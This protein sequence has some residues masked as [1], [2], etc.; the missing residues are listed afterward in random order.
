M[1][2]ITAFADRK[3]GEKY[4]L[5]KH[6]SGL[7]IYV[8]PKKMTL[9]TALLGV[10]FGSV[11]ETGA[12]ADGVRREYPSGIAHF[13]EHKLFSSADGVDA[14]EVL[15]SLGAD[16]NAY[17]SNNKTVYMFSCTE[18]FTAAL[19]ELVNF[20][21][22][23][24][25]TNENVESERGI[26]TQEIRMCNDS[27]YDA[28][29][30]NLLHALFGKGKLSDDV[31]GTER[32][33]DRIDAKTL[34]D[35]YDAFYRYSNM[36]L[37]VC[38]DVS[39]EEVVK[40]VDGALP[41]REEQSAPALPQI[42]YEDAVDKPIIEKVMPVAQTVLEIGIK[43][44]VPSPDVLTRL[45]RDVLL[46]ILDEMLFSRAGELY[47]GLFEEG[48]INESYSYGYSITRDVAFHSIY[49]ESERPHEVLARVKGYI[50][51][52]KREG[53]SKRDFI[54]C[55]RVMMAE[56]IRDFDSVDDIANSLLNFVFE[57]ADIFEYGR[58][59]EDV[60][61]AE[62]CECFEDSFDEE[63]YALSII[64]NNQFSEEKTNA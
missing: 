40:A 8:F 52:K 13:L 39:V 3:L 25:F 1:N 17:T 43:D 14:T 33:I 12:A 24:Y 27:P 49:A 15:A 20:V 41:E 51:L 19:A 5:I 59:I 32:T 64:K 21:Y 55:K 30:Q 36:A 56:F 10:R 44:G 53:L 45:R 29:S 23:P 47:N 16:A 61:F 60:T 37:V 28:V 2:N 34:Y 54:R 35:C 48:L 62:L 4:Y 9:S 57:G 46:T 11:Y 31:L 42:S 50:A 22:A 38:G 7:D 6:K 26:I 63:C 18:N 58:I